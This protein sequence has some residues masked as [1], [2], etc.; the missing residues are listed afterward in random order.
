MVSVEQK[1]TPKTL[2]IQVLPDGFCVLIPDASGK[3]DRQ[4]ITQQDEL[5]QWIS[6]RPSKELTLKLIY[7]HP[8]AIVPEEVFSASHASTY[9]KFHLE[10]WEQAAFTTI[11]RLGLRIVFGS[12][13]ELERALSAT[14]QQLEISHS[15]HELFKRVLIGSNPSEVGIVS[16]FH[17]D[18]LEAVFHQGSELLAYNQFKIQGDLD[19]SYYLSL[20]Q[21]TADTP[22]S[23]VICYEN[24]SEWGERSVLHIK[25]WAPDTQYISEAFPFI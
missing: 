6:S 24:G 22:A 25:E 1:T 13:N 20:L 15:A 2:S 9:L 10:D 16:L 14:C 8:A 23:A 5:L 21:Q 12:D 11:E 3:I 19:A 17:P 7:T 18:H 4:R